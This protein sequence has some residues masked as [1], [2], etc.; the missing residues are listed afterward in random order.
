MSRHVIQGSHVLPL[1]Q[2]CELSFFLEIDWADDG[3]IAKY[4]IVGHESPACSLVDANACMADDLV[5]HEDT[6][7][8]SC[9]LY[10]G[11]VVS[12][13]LHTCSG[14]SLLDNHMAGILPSSINMAFKS[15][16][17]KLAACTGATMLNITW[18][19]TVL[20]FS[21]WL[22]DAFDNSRYDNV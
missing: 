9:H 12:S 1:G 14:F 8:P 15:R 18:I 19:F 20:A 6:L 17:D 3:E 22:A 5:N 2:C 10:S 13:F 7:S 4:D 11:A 21:T 16:N